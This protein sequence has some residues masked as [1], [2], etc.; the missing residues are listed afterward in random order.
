MAEEKREKQ[1]R[2]LKEADEEYLAHLNLCRGC[3]VAHCPFGI[4][5]YQVKEK[6]QQSL[7]GIKKEVYQNKA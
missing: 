4:V 6:L 3:Y 5:K 7:Y 2:L 1:L